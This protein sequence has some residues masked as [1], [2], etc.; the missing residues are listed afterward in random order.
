M[1]EAG[2]TVVVWVRAVSVGPA[3]SH[4][5]MLGISEDI[6]AL[7]IAIVGAAVWAAVVVVAVL[8]VG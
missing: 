1:I 4:N 5:G 8:V 7:A 6:R 3:V 2:S